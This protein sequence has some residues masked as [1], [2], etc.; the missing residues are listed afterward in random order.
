M[1]VGIHGRKSLKNL[2]ITAIRCLMWAQQYFFFYILTFITLQYIKGISGFL[3]P[4]F[5]TECIPDLALN[6]TRGEF[7]DSNYICTNPNI[8][9]FVQLNY[10]RSFP[11]LNAMIAAYPM[12]FILWY[13]HRRIS[14]VPLLFPILATIGLAWILQASITRITEHH[15]HSVDIIGSFILVIPFSVYLVS[16]MYFSLHQLEFNKIYN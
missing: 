15:H 11:S 8:T 4:Y 16:E 12:V 9:A 14:R 13:L 3:R 6:C 10:A 1:E 7:I 2:F 5:L